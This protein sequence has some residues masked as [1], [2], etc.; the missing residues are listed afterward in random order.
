MSEVK[1]RSKPQ[2]AGQ[3]RRRAEIFS[4][5]RIE[6]NSPL[7]VREKEHECLFVSDCRLLFTLQHEF[8]HSPILSFI[9]QCQLLSNFESSLRGLSSSRT[10]RES[11]T[12]PV[13][14]SPIDDRRFEFVCLLSLP[15]SFVTVFTNVLNSI[16]VVSHSLS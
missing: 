8:F 4:R 16:Q 7:K 1:V 5:L 14:W 6:E 9:W 3:T 15:C 2:R 13:L 11:C 12:K 10:H